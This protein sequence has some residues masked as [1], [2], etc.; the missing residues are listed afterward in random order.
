MS[1]KKIIFAGTPQ[2]SVP[3]LQALLDSQHTVCAVYTQPDRPAGRGR[4][5][6]ASPVKQLALAH[7]IPIYQPPTL[8]T[9]A[10]QTELHTLQA[11]LMIVVAYGL[12]LPMAVL[13]AFRFGCINV[14][15]SLLP[16]WRGA[17][18]IQRALLAGDVE[19]GI[20]LM[21]MDIGLDT[22]AMLATKHCPIEPTDTGQ[23]LHDKLSLLGATILS[24]SIDNIENL[25]RKN[26]DSSQATYAHKLDKAEA[27]L[28]WTKSA[29]ELERA[30]RAYNPF[31]MAQTTLAGYTLRI[32]EAQALP[33]ETATAGDILR[34]N[35]QGIDIATGAGVL[36]LLKVQK[37]GGKMLSVADFLN[38]H[39]QLLT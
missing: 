32:G 27:Q 10:A 18:P 17:A 35:K 15:A 3:C 37:S 34:I 30:V 2:F 26:Q 28:D 9:T 31:P 29:L 38:G 1:I 33:A 8:K 13:D 21:Q 5:L 16:R 20:T 7:Q 24:Q 6:Q 4:Q 14:H 23:T 11:D 19:T 39:K 22:G 25:E 36:R 12:L